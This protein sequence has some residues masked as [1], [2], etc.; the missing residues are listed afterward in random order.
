MRTQKTQIWPKSCGA[1]TAL[2]T[3]IELGDNIKLTNEQ[4]NLIYTQLKG[5]RGGADAFEILPHKIADYMIASGHNVT[6]LESP[7]T[8]MMLLPHMPGLKP[9][10]QLYKAGLH[11]G[12]PQERRSAREGDLDNNARLFLVVRINGTN[13]THYLLARKDNNTQY[14]MNPA[15]GTDEAINIPRE[16]DTIKTNVGGHG[17]GGE[18]LYTYLGIA[19][20]V[21]KR[22]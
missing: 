10:Y 1:A 7:A 22:P 11:N 13:L 4:E 15:P 9:M 16:G 18:R 17:A 21:W 20:R 5:A 8:K 14:I 2:V 3:R 12:I 6:I 19:I